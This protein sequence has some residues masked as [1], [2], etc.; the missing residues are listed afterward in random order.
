MAAPPKYH[1]IV[2]KTKLSLFLLWK[3]EHY[4]E[5]TLLI[6]QVEE[7]KIEIFVRF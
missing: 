6:S 2:D 3:R 7:D 5:R 4:F 1:Q